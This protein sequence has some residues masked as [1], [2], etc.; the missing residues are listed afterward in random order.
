M[1]VYD[2]NEPTER[3]YQC[4]E[5]EYGPRSFKPQCPNCGTNIDHADF[6]ETPGG[7]T[8]DNQ[9]RA[10]PPHP[11]AIECIQALA[12]RVARMEETWRKLKGIGD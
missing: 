11:S 6:S 1:T 7:A 2:A 10:H 5:S 12:L 8:E 9:R 4:A 3:C